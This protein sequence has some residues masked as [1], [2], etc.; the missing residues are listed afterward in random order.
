ME[1]DDHNH[2]M[3]VLVCDD[4]PAD[5]KLVK[6]CLKEVV[7]EKLQVLEAGETQEIETALNQHSP[8]IVFMDLQMPGK[9]GL[10]W[11]QEIVS[12]KLAPVIMLTG[13]GNEDVAVTSLRIGAA[14]YVSKK[15]LKPRS[16]LEA[17]SG[18]K[19]VWQ[20]DKLL[21]SSVSASVFDASPDKRLSAIGI[22]T[23]EALAVMTE[24]RDPYTA[25]HQ[26]R[27]S[28]LAKALAEEM[29]LPQDQ[30]IAVRLAGIIHDIG[31]VRVPSEILTN[32]G[33]LTESEFNIIKTH[34]KVG[35]DIIRHIELPWPISRIIREH[36]ERND[37]SG[38]PAALHQ[39][40]IALESRILAVADVVE[41]M[42]SH[43]P[44]RPALGL[45]QAL[46]EISGKR[47]IYDSAVVEACLSLFNEKRYQLL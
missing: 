7:G 35:Y 27:V 15:N 14:G 13:Y 33:R 28:E 1:I 39:K 8:D 40:D 5:R 21:D 19:T 10:Q 31:K 6:Y 23:V 4:D 46:S 24:M 9:S 38:Y 25:G 20:N 26:R 47:N 30:I 36:H 2:V 16:L 12:R 41:A 45:E 18:V 3:K 34:P 32:P 43:R 44:Y 37:G 11:L 29:K 22:E 17:I 42:A